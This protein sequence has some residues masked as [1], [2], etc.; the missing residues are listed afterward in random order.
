M[1]EAHE[2]FERR[3]RP[4]A[5]FLGLLATVGC[6]VALGWLGR[7][8]MPQRNASAMAGLAGL[9]AE[10][11]APLVVVSAAEEAALNPPAEFIGHVEPI[12]D[13]DLRAQI[14]G[15]VKAIHFV[16]GALVREGDLLFSID[17]DQYEARVAL[18][19]AELEKEKAELD[20]AEKFQKRLEASDTRGITQSDL[21]TARSA[22][23]QS[24]A[25]VQQAHANLR[26]AEIDLKHTRIVAPIAGRIGR[27]VA[28]VGDYVAPSLGTLVR[29]VQMNPVRVVFSVTDREYLKVRESIADEAIQSTLRTRLRLPTGT[30]LDVPGVR[31][32]E[33][34]EMSMDTATLPVRVRFENAQGL[35][36]PGGYVT[37]LI[38]QP[39][40]AKGPVVPLSAVTADQQGSYVYTVSAEGK[41][42]LQRVKIGTVMG[43]RVE[44]REGLSAGDRV[45]VEGVQK[46]KPGQSVQAVSAADAARGGA[47]AAPAPKVD[48]ATEGGKQ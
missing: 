22:V 4:V 19:Q 35:L 12:R 17:P 31:D 9:H 23:A 24:R 27:T 39:N 33:N 20:R 43:G 30:V 40:A 5:K 38:D 7:G 8:L 45:V 21:D 3:E 42:Q 10:A 47:P 28:N 1:N 46:V 25:A 34:N 18:R 37:V 29:I 14:A 36:V 16:E 32:F 11:A 44:I 26:L 48:G 6:S 13:V 2:T 15:Y 41:A